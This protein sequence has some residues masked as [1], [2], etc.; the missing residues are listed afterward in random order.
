MILESNK[1]GFSFK[2][3]RQVTSKGSLSAK[4]L[5]KGETFK[6]SSKKRHME[7]MIHEQT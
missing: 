4:L 2:K 1:N 6:A 5:E 7:Y 3:K